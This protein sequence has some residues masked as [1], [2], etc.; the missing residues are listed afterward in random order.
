MAAS[1]GT[2]G[3]EGH[4]ADAKRT[5]ALCADDFGLSDS[6]DE[7]VLTLI[8]RGRLTAT[9]CMVAGPRFEA[10]APDLAALADRADVGLHFTLTDLPPLGA[11]PKFSPDGTAPGLGSVLARGYTGRLDY[12]EIAAEF[13]RQLDRFRAV[14]GRAPDFVD[15]HQHVH[16]LPASK[17][18]IFAAFDEGRLDP[19]RT[20]LRDCGDS[21]GSILRRGV[22][23]PKTLLL[24][25]MSMGLA[26][27]ARRRGIRV[28]D[29]FRGITA[30]AA[31]GGYGETF[32]R[33]LGGAGDR[34]LAMCHPAVPGPAEG[35]P[36]A[37]ARREEWAYFSGADF[38]VDLAEA[39]VRLVRATD[40]PA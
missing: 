24:T 18:A 7:A 28:N 30:F 4:G 25:V 38:P 22:E 19:E 2:V 15:G 39:G 40:Q 23:V 29:G 16:L 34:P 3:T 33:F 31:D 26:G 32:R 35:D 14:F 27:A 5:L 10:D 12:S 36:I 6:I 1:G 37:A 21:I 17:R 11:M 9:S 20:W 8:A 13:G